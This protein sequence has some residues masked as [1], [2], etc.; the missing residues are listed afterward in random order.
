MLI[1]E[2]VDAVLREQLGAGVEWDGETSLTNGTGLALDSLD[3]VEFV[4]G[5]ENEFRIEIPDDDLFA[6]PT[7][8]ELH[9]RSGVDRV[10]EVVAYVEGRL[11]TTPALAFG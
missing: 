1:R 11:G 8:R 7:G 5:L 2:R 10:R 6:T 9:W 3:L 4:I